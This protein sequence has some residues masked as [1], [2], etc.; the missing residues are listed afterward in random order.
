MSRSENA[1][2]ELTVRHKPGVTQLRRSPGPRT[3]AV[4]LANGSHSSPRVE[5]QI[6]QSMLEADRIAGIVALP[7][8]LFGTT[9]IPTCL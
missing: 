2:V 4:A 1:A 3:T 8:Q 9:Q 7:P 5:P 6:R